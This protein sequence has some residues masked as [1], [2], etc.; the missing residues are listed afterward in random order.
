MVFEVLRF[1]GCLKFLSD[2]QILYLKLRPNLQTNLVGFVISVISARLLVWVSKISFRPTTI[3][4]LVFEFFEI[5]RFFSCFTF[6]PDRQIL[7]VEVIE[8][9]VRPAN[10][11]GLGC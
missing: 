7:W 4:A 8:L 9:S 5:L 6:W 1:F 3:E 11:V 10:F 2:L